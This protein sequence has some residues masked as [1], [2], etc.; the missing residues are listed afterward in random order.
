MTV[1]THLEPAHAANGGAST[2]SGVLISGGDPFLVEVRAADPVDAQAIERLIK[3]VAGRRWSAPD[4]CWAVPAWEAESLEAAVEAIE[5]FGFFVERCLPDPAGGA[6]MPEEPSGVR[7]S[8]LDT[9][10]PTVPKPSDV[11]TAQHRRARTRP[12]VP[13]PGA[14]SAP[15]RPNIPPAA[16][17]SEMGAAAEAVAVAGARA[18]SRGGVRVSGDG[19]FAVKVTA[20]PSTF[21]EVLSAVQSVAGRNYDE[22]SQLWRIPERSRQQLMRALAEIESLGYWVEAEPSTADQ[23]DL[24]AGSSAPAATADLRSGDGRDWVFVAMERDLFALRSKV[25]SAAPWLRWSN[26]VGALYGPPPRTPAG[27]RSMSEAFARAGVDMTTRLRAARPADEAPSAGEN[28]LTATPVQLRPYQI[29]GA[30]FAMRYGRVLLADEPSLGKNYQALAAVAAGGACPCVIVCPPSSRTAWLAETARMCPDADVGILDERIVEAPADFMVLSYSDLHDLRS[31]LPATP[32]AVIFD[33]IQYIKNPDTRRTTAAAALA[34]SAAPDAMVI[35][36][37]GTPMRAKPKPRDL[38]PFLEMTG[39]IRRFGGTEAYIAAFCGPRD[40]HAN[41]RKV[42]T[43]EGATNLPLLE[44]VLADGIMIRRRKRDVASDLP[45]KSARI[46]PVD[47]DPQMADLYRRCELAIAESVSD[48]GLAALAELASYQRS[49][50]EPASHTDDPSA[51]TDPAEM[52]LRDIAK[53]APTA[54]AAATRRNVD[55]AVAAMSPEARVVFLRRLVAAAK[56]PAV[57]DRIQDWLDCSDTDRKLVVFAHD[58]RIVRAIVERFD[59]AMLLPSMTADQR[60]DAVTRF[61]HNASPRVV[62]CAVTDETPELR[63][64]PRASDVIFAEQPWSPTEC[65]QAEDQCHNTADQHAVMVEYVVA[66]DTIDEHIAALV[67][68]R[69]S[70][71]GAA[72]E[73]GDWD[74]ILRSAVRRWMRGRCEPSNRT[75][76]RSQSERLW[77]DPEA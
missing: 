40:V 61:N 49:L 28:K 45:A 22:R 53:G 62:V 5:T 76:V 74:T 65:D 60:A 11:R 64:Q 68:R 7:F 3:I 36:L 25:A 70:A 31:R 39:L 77:G 55:A 19:P 34:A 17:P 1:T 4:A 38:L 9:S 71:A 20:P 66:S 48:S 46:T 29:E 32:K 58:L 2:R 13:G 21:R 30:A 41:G 33:D 26:R 51:T 73:G 37:S 8:L 16:D 35:G 12:E 24:F 10:P 57:V 72:M 6:P 67:E 14:V 47:L 43:I 44:A 59:A 23:P 63:S 56:L 69:R 50:F 54:A 18:R 15:E 27:W 52:A 42:R 75:G